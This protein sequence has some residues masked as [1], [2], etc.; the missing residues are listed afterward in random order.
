[1]KRQDQS[2]EQRALTNRFNESLAAI[3]TASLNQDKQFQRGRAAAFL[4]ALSC[5]DW[6]TH[7]EFNAG[8]ERIF[9]PNVAPKA[10]RKLPE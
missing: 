4:S 9:P 7:E 5:L 3:D 10:A 6:V 8:L 1:M 2:W